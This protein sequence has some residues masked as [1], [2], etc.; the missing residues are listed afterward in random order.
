MEE[1]L[2]L[3]P[4]EGAYEEKRRYE[5]LSC[6]YVVASRDEQG[7]IIGDH[8]DSNTLYAVPP[9]TPPPPKKKHQVVISRNLVA[10][11]VLWIFTRNERRQSER[12]THQ[13]H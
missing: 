11:V 2:H 9:P 5:K 1:L 4:S 12:A 8:T 13:I 6:F 10:D 3:K 7:T